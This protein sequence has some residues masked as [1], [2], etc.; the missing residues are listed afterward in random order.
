MLFITFTCFPKRVS[1]S[2]LAPGTKANSG[3]M[4]SIKTDVLLFAGTQEFLRTTGHRFN[5]LRAVQRAMDQV[6]D[7][8][9]S[10]QLFKPQLHAQLVIAAEGSYVIE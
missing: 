3:T 6:T 8:E 1:I 4:I 5:K 7:E 2:V 9:L 10:R